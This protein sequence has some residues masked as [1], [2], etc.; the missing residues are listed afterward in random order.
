MSEILKMTEFET[1]EGV[2][3]VTLIVYVPSLAQLLLA[4]L[5]KVPE[6]VI[7][8]GK[9]LPF[10]RVAVQVMLPQGKYGP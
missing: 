2:V 5:N 4:M 7:P 10:E 3:P 9:A 1:P 8:A 6:N